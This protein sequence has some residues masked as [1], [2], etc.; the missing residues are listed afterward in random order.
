MRLFLTFILSFYTIISFSQWSDDF[1]DGDFTANPT[2]SGQVSNFDIDISNKLHLNAPAVSDTS[3]LSVLSDVVENA[4]WEFL[5][6]LDFNPSSSNLARVYLTSN[7]ADLKGSL[8]GYF[9]KIGNTNDEVSL[10]RQDGLTTS[11]IIDG[12]DGTVSGS[13]NSVRVKVTRDVNGNWELLI[14]DTGGTTYISQGTALDNTYFSSA[15]AGV[16][17]KY[18]STRSTKF[19]FDD[20][21]VT[22]SPYVDVSLPFVLS[23][24]ATSINSVDVLFSEDMNQASVESISNYSLDNGIGSPSSAA[25][26]VSNL[27][28]VHLTFG[29]NFTN[30]TSYFLTTSNVSDLA[31]NVLTNSADNF[32]YFV[33]D[34]AIGFDVLIT[35][36]MADY[37]P[38]QGLPQLEYIEIYNNS[39]K[40]F[41][42]NNWMVSDASSTV[43][44]GSYILL[45]G[46]Y[47]I[48]ADGTSSTYGQFNILQ[49]QLPSLNNSGD[50]IVLK[51][52]L[53]TTIDSI[54]YDLS[55]YHDSNK[56]DGG[57]SIE[58]KRLSAQCSNDNNWGASVSPIG[59]TPGVQNSIYT[60]QTDT[61]APIVIDYLI[62]NDTL[63]LIFDESVDGTNLNLDITPNLSIVSWQNGSDNQIEVVL[64]SLQNNTVYEAVLNNVINCWGTSLTDYKMV[65]GKPLAV[66]K[67]DVVI[68]EIMFNPLTNGS[69]YVEIVNI[70]DKVLDL[71]G[72]MLANIQNDTI[73]NF[74][75]IIT[76]QH[77]FLPGD[78]V[79]ISPD[80]TDI[81]HDFTIYGIGT[82]ID[83]D[84]PTYPNDSGSV[85]LIDNNNQVLDFV[86]Y[87]DAY[88][89]ELLSS[90]DGKALE[91]ISFTGASNNP[92]NWHTAS[93][94]VEW[95][96]PGYL[97]SQYLDDSISGDVSLNT[98]IFS[99]DNDGYQDVV[100]INYEF[101]NPDNVMDVDIFD[102]KGRMIR[103]LKDGYYPGIKGFVTWDGINDD[104]T[105]TQTGTYIMLITVFDLKGNKTN[106][107]KVVVLASKL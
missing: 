99:P 13:T 46:Q 94:Q 62:L 27:A 48:L 9:V 96:T 50:D 91:R 71:N 54:S 92:D 78:Y 40:S 23:V 14:D 100:I 57:W 69:D 15:Y 79:L 59:G 12:V 105:K 93:E 82:F 42:L 88:Q 104:G 97:N 34:V 103:K 106:Y 1:T 81:I 17:C 68:N 28:L 72:W 86:H 87:D 58:R 29:T 11:Q 33:P 22:G 89:F 67:G 2:W 45:P 25:L 83:T 30:N 31:G 56:N 35:E 26:D 39:N 75:P 37:S 7:Q 32:T 63:T 98:K 77:L 74:K 16:Q 6:D 80:S 73:N 70:S 20:F 64:S 107:K 85:I 41:D 60:T 95:G 53:G 66:E 55:W 76:Q 52:D 24:T 61:S 4:T 19:H 90:T 3:Y 51:N 43:V 44:L 38:S 65:F 102:S 18:T 5:V 8:N 49:T 21:V 84:L 47:V 10:Y 101:T 36:F